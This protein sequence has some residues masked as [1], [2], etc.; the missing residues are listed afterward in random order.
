MLFLSSYQK[1]E[2]TIVTL[3]FLILIC[4]GREIILG[5]VPNTQ[6]TIVLTL[7]LFIWLGLTKA[8]SNSITYNK[9][10]QKLSFNNF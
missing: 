3:L 5:K 8:I 2:I 10:A 4:F 1:F 7:L 6:Y 9:T